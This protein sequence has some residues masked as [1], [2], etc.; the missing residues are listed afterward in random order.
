MSDHRSR[1]SAARIRDA[2]EE[3][4]DIAPARRAAWLEH[5]FRD[6]PT[7]REEVASLLEAYDEAAE[8]L[9]RLESGLGRVTP[10]AP[11]PQD[12]SGRRLSKY[13]VLE[14]IGE[15][16]MGVVYRARDMKLDRNVAL[17]FIRTDAVLTKEDRARI[18]REAQAAASLSHSNI[19]TV[20]EIEDADGHTFIA[21]ECVD[22]EGLDVLIAEGRVTMDDAI[23]IAIQIA[24][25]LQA[26]HEEGVVHRDVKSSNIIVT[27][28]GQA[29]IVDFGLARM[30]E[31]SPVTREG[32]VFGTVPYMS[33]EQA[34]D[35]QVDHRTDIWSLGVV[36]YEMLSGRRPFGGS[37]KRELM[38][39]I[40][41]EAP[42][43]LRNRIPDAS[44][45]V[46][47]IVERALAKRMEDRYESAADMLRDLKRHRDTVRAGA[48]K[49]VDVKALFHRSREPRFAVP[50]MLG[51]LAFVAVTV[52]H[53]RHQASIQ[54]AQEEALPK[55]EQLI[56]EQRFFEAFSL[57]E[58]ALSHVPDDRML[59]TLFE[60]SAVPVTIESEPSGARFLYKSYL[61]PEMPWREAGATPLVDIRLPKATIRWRM[62]MDGHEPAEGHFATLWRTLNV[63]L[64]PADQAQTGMAWIPPGSV[65]VAGQSVALD[66]FW[67]DR[68]E[69]TNA[70][71]ARFVAAGG[72]ENPAFWRPALEATGLTWEEARQAFRDQTDRPGPAIWEFGAPP[73]GSGD[74]PVG[75][76]SWFEAG[77]FCNFAGKELPT[78]YHWR[79]VAGGGSERDVHGAVGR[80]S[81][82]SGEGPAPR[83]HHS[84]I[85]RHGL[86][87][88]AG[89]LKEWVWNASR[90][91]RHL[92]GGAWNEPSYLY[93]DGDMRL[94]VERDETHGFRCALYHEPISDILREPIPTTFYDFSSYR[95]VED[96]VFHTLQRF[97]E[98]EPDPLEVHEERVEEASNWRRETVSF[99]AGY[100]GERLLAHV[101]IPTSAVP[102]YHTVVYFPGVN[103]MAPGL[104]QI[105]NDLPLIDFI[106][107]SG[108]VLVYP[109]YRHMHERF[110]PNWQHSVVSHRERLI[111]WRQDLG[112][113][114][115]YLETRPDVDRETIAFFGFSL[116]ASLGPVFGA[117]EERLAML[118]LMG[119]GVGY[120]RSSLPPELLSLNYAPRVQAPVLK[121]GGR[122]DAIFGPPQMERKP[123]FDLLGTPEEHKRFV[124]LEGGHIP[125]WSEVIRETLD[126]L[127]RYQGPVFRKPEE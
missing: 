112:R 5:Q 70:E 83:G 4:L 84:G 6:D 9:H 91:R 26:A 101:F 56:G 71:F 106:V 45:D 115:D 98:Y 113:T 80:M 100:G 121:I 107:R 39:S 124:L 54:W 85:S 47:H 35:E 11:V 10:D 61:D 15:G 34:R 81:N 74:L 24:E 87:D 38:H 3:V 67:M 7:V 95:P 23:D 89:N 50:A 82:F 17:K 52:W 59:Q 77:A 57:V 41:T 75:G 2:F 103:A 33:P 27:A 29:K 69:V 66:A 127:D 120:R 49:A 73:E 31:V 90:E 118:I 117:V 88:L 8:V 16:G 99:N 25:G 86:Y 28:K 32:V 63:P 55:I 46:I 68:Y 37:G 102:P 22:G 109:V 53:A 21:M 72:Y 12:F 64:L 126:W 114:L 96:E 110:V 30:R 94:P 36:L 44:P 76:V 40:L 18:V 1:E 14:K 65:N 58:K 93:I 105:P 119:G 108:R 13:R 92:L 116:G 111:H 19:A 62:E 20:Y 125:D 43:P 122:D 104:S 48:A 60:E 51:L 123:L 78:V 79:R 42:E 97:F